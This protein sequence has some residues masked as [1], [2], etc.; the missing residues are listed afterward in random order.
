M[1]V[2]AGGQRNVARN[3]SGVNR[4]SRTVVLPDARAGSSWVR[5]DIGRASTEL[6]RWTPSA[7][8]GN[9]A[10]HCRSPQARARRLMVTPLGRDVVPDVYRIRAGSCG[11]ICID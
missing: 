6:I 4:S 9:T 11:E 5:T 3:P 2:L 10:S 1:C 7:A 8:E